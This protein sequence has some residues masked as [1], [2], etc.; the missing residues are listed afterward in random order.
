[1]VQCTEEAERAWVCGGA[2]YRGGSGNEMVVADELN[3]VAGPFSRD[4][5]EIPRTS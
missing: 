3:H 5:L 2:E 4:F 1:M